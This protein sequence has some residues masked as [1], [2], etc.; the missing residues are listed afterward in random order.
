[1]GRQYVRQSSARA[2]RA[3]CSLL[4]L[5]AERMRLQRVV[6]NSR[7]PASPRSPAFP[8]TREHCGSLSSIQAING[9]YT[10]PPQLVA[11]ARMRSLLVRCLINS[12]SKEIGLDT[13]PAE[14]LEPTRS[15]DHWILSPARLPIPP[16]RRSGTGAKGYEIHVQAQ[17][18]GALECPVLS[19]SCL[20]GED[21]I[22]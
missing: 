19:G 9:E 18:R 8:F 13:L 20:H 7:G 16:R 14:G 6:I 22:R 17:H 2:S 10:A 21:A 4:P 15:C 1:M 12:L 3:F 5:A 11:F